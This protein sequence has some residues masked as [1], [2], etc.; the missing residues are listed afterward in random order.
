MPEKKSTCP[1][2]EITAQ[3]RKSNLIKNAVKAYGKVPAD[4]YVEL[5]DKSKEKVYLKDTLHQV[6]STYLNEETGE[7]IVAFK[8]ECSLCG[9][10]YN[11]NKKMNIL[12]GK[13]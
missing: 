2:C 12:E 13:C 6:H 5:R 3:A 9:F 7:L 11:L 4:E 1:N 10:I 8:C